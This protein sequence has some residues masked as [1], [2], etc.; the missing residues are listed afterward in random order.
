MI[1]VSKSEKSDFWERKKVQK[2]DAIKARFFHVRFW[3]IVIG[4]P[5]GFSKPAARKA[6]M[7]PRRMLFFDKHPIYEERNFGPKRWF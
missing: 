4:N 7:T 3:K 6:E 5:K 2:S 1:S